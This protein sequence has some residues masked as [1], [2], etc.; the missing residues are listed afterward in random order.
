MVATRH[1]SVGRYEKRVAR[2]TVVAGITSGATEVKL[3]PRDDLDRLA[4]AMTRAVE[5]DV[6]G[7]DILETPDGALFGIEVNANFGFYPRNRE[8]VDAVVERLHAVARRSR[9]A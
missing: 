1:A 8:I 3:A 4:V 6:A 9:S 2:G 7:A 5:M